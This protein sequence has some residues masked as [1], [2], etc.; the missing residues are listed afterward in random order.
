M[1]PFKRWIAANRGGSVHVESF[2]GDNPTIITILGGGPH[3]RVGQH[4]VTC[5]VEG[6]YMTNHGAILRD[7]TALIGWGELVVLNA[8]V[9]RHGIISAECSECELDGMIFYEGDYICA[10]CRERFEDGV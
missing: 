3:L 8:S 9:W 6:A 10:W 5:R 7:C 4:F 2:D 1:T